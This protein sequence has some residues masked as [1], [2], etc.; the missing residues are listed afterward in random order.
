MAGALDTEKACQP[1][2]CISRQGSIDREFPHDSFGISD[3]FHANWSLAKEPGSIRAGLPEL[4]VID[5][6]TVVW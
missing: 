6:M 5:G 1:S 3:N 4:C 2:S